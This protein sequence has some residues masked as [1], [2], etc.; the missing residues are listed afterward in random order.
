MEDLTNPGSAD[1]VRELLL[2]VV[3]LIIRAI[4]KRKLKKSLQNADSVAK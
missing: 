4:E 2:I 1:L 3:G